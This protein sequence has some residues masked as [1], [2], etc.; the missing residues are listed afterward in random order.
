VIPFP[1][2]DL[3]GARVGNQAL[4]SRWHLELLEALARMDGRVSV[5]I[6][7]ATYATLENTP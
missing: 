1:V 2:C 7:G 3:C 6:A 4:H 5:A